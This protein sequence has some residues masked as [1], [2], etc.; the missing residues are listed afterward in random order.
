MINSIK[1]HFRKPISYITL[2]LALFDFKVS[3]LSAVSIA[4]TLDCFKKSLYM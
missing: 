2:A 1:K 3:K 4:G